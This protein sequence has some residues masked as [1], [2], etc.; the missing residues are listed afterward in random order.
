M[1]TVTCSQLVT[2]WVLPGK[3]IGWYV[4]VRVGGYVSDC[5]YWDSFNVN[6]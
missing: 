4:R 1:G 2:P 3:K 6:I 5:A